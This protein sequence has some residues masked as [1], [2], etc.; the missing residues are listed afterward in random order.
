V[1]LVTGEE[2]LI[3]S[4]RV[5]DA[6]RASISIPGIFVP[7]RSGSRIL[8][9]GALRNPVPVSALEDLGAD[10]RVAVN[11]HH[12]PVREIS[13]PS[14]AADRASS[15]RRR[16]RTRVSEALERGRARLRGAPRPPPGTPESAEDETAPNLLEILTA[17][18]SV[19][20]YELARHRLRHD[21]VDLVIEPDV[22]GIRTFEFQKARQAIAA[23]LR[24]VE[25]H[26]AEI[27]RLVS[28]RSLRR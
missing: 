18:M 12:A 23:G 26:I 25:P 5:I 4:G 28:R 27:Q 1:D 16:I 24:D 8:V 22:H 6:V 9:D 11:L 20:E 10:V 17:S 7:Y 15:S 21:P 13:R 3:R 19:L 2:V 14:R